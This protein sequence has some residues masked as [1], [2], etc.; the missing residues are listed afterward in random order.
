MNLKDYRMQPDE[1]LFE[2]IERRLKV[3]RMVRLGSGVAAVAVVAGLALWMAV[4]SAS[5]EGEQTARVTEAL[6]SQPQIVTNAIGIEEHSATAA[7][8]KIPERKETK[9]ISSMP[10]IGESERREAAAEGKNNLEKAISVS[11]PLPAAGW[12]PSAVV[13]SAGVPEEKVSMGVSTVSKTEEVRHEEDVESHDTP[14]VVKAGDPTAV[15]VHIDNLVWA[16][17]AIA[18]NGDVDENRRFKL[19]YSSAVSDF[20]IHIY[21]RGGRLVFTSVDP[22]FEW[23]GTSHGTTLPQG[24]YV[25]VARFRDSTGRLCQ[26]KGTVTIVR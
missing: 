24:A 13:A 22:S 23:D 16:P 19:S 1:G 15:P 5:V 6:P 10:Q 14:E 3:R 8:A 21:N 7:S 12:E 2:K 9:A 25:W 17:N 4:P 26:E 20:R 18:P 11:Q